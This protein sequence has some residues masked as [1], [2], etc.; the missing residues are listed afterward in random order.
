M[1][2]VLDLCTGIGGFSLA[3][4]WLVG[5][6]RTVCYVEIDKYCQQVIQARIKDGYLD[7]APIWSDLKTFDGRP[8]RGSVDI[9]TAGFPCTPHSVA[10]KRLHGADKN[11]LWPEVK[12]VIGEVRPDIVLCENVPGITTYLPV[13]YNDFRELGYCTPPPLRVSAATV[14]AGHL[15]RRIFI[16]AYANGH[17]IRIKHWRGK[18]ASGK[19]EVIATELG[20]LFTNANCSRL[21]DDSWRSKD[22][23][24]TGFGTAHGDNGNEIYANITCGRCEATE[25]P[26]RQRTER[27]READA[28]RV[29]WFQAEPGLDRLVYG[30]SSRLVKSRIAADGRSVVP[31]VVAKAWEILAP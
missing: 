22:A 7:D 13:V 25:I 24:R 9:I 29:G 31:A 8:W 15:R 6:F 30:V 26:E 5:G 21:P 3:L 14:G 17:G 28:L 20:P 18:W 27:E 10:G 11:N 16:S 4:R 19:S 1:N 23:E 2:Y 12:R